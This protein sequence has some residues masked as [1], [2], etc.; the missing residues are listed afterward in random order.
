MEKIPGMEPQKPDA[1][2]KCQL[3]RRAS[4]DV[5]T[6]GAHDQLTSQSAIRRPDDELEAASIPHDLK[7]H[8]EIGGVAATK[9]KMI[10]IKITKVDKK[11]Y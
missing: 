4:D 10:A 1:R 5:T 2:T 7:R 3:N 11:L 6:T 8:N 9:F